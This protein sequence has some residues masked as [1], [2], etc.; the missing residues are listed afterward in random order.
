MREVKN[1]YIKPP[2][3]ITD[4]GRLLPCDEHKVTRD[5]NFTDCDFHP[6]L[7]GDFQDCRINNIM[8]PNGLG[9]PYFMQRYIKYGKPNAV[10]AD[11]LN[12]AIAS[13]PI[14]EQRSVKEHLQAILDSRSEFQ[15]TVS[16][17]P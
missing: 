3:D 16:S 12:D 17:A 4:Y 2:N 15:S 5:C 1:W 9:R 13:L 8:I 10:S 14:T 7:I 11:S 6:S